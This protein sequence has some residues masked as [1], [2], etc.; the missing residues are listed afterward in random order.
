M[1]RL[2]QHLPSTTQR[3]YFAQLAGTLLLVAAVRSAGSGAAPRN[4][5]AASPAAVA[6]RAGAAPH[7]ATAAPRDA[8]RRIVVSIPDRKLALVEDG[9][10]V[11]VYRVA[12]GADVS[13]SP[14]GALRIV[15]RVTR[16]TYYHP[17][18]VIPPGKQN[19][20]GTRWI[21][22]SAAGYG[23]HGTNEPASIGRRASHGC[24]RMRNRDVEDLFARVGVGDAVELVGERTEEVAE[25]FGGKP[26]PRL[27]T[28]AAVALPVASTGNPE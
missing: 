3:N 13:P 28:A 19:P 4:P 9:R 21:G 27:V 7:D 5:S 23:I 26:A 14:T 22:L 2:L 15:H 10:V 20:L 18:K 17:G 8:V 6:P 16:P 24:I 11:K 25:I 1:R 12:V